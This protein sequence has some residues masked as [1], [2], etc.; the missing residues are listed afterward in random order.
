MNKTTT[1]KDMR[2]VFVF[3]GGGSVSHLFASEDRSELEAAIH[4]AMR[5]GDWLNMGRGNGAESAVRGSMVA[6][7]YFT[8]A[9]ASS[10]EVAAQAIKKIADSTTDGESWRQ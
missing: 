8:D 10:S 1:A 3:S 2:I 5:T 6:G 4:D 9:G 7:W